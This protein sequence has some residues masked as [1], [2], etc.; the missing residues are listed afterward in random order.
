MN[1][2]LGILGRKLGCT[3]IFDDEGFVHRVTVL[4]VGPCTV[5]DKRTEERDGYWAL[6]LGFEARSSK[7]MKKP[8]IG[9]Y[10]KKDSPLEK[11]GVTPKRNLREVRVTREIADRWEVGQT[12]SASDVFESGQFVD[13]TGTTK[14]RG[15]TGVFKRWGFRGASRT[16]GS[17]EYF[18]HGGSI[19]QC[20]TPGRTFKG[21][22]MPGQHGNRRKTVQNLRVVDVQG[23]K[24]LLLVRGA[25]PGRT[26]G[27]V[28]IRHAAKKAPVGP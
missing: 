4:E 7:N 3:Q 8:E 26:R 14:G 11:A 2:R 25:V 23:E 19:G 5:V 6:V 22:K 28:M 24:N 1:Q 16:H 18:R 9:L 17:H 15:F 27:L 20:M 10:T 21:L 13:V 12:I